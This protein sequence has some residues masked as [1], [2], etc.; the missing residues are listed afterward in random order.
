MRTS[1]AEHLGATISPRACGD[2]PMR[3]IFCLSE[4]AAAQTALA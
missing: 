1:A 4:T 2:E 3:S